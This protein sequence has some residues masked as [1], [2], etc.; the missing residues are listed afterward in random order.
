MRQAPQVFFLRFSF[1]FVLFFSSLGCCWFFS[2]MQEVDKMASL[3]TMFHYFSRLIKKTHVSDI[4]YK[5]HYSNLYILGR[6]LHSSTAVNVYMLKHFK[7]WIVYLFLQKIF[8]PVIKRTLVLKH[9]LVPA[10]KFKTI[11]VVVQQ[12]HQVN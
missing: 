3:E 5:N 6:I 9:H 2:I 7:N 4:L 8:L 11:I 10:M 1:S 12:V